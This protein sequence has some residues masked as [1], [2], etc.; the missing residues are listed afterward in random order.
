MPTDLETLRQRLDEAETA[1]H[2]L[3]L[4]ELEVTV[5]VVGFGATNYSQTNRDQLER[6]IAKLKSDIA[7]HTGLARRGP[8]FFK[9]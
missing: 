2:R 8:I 5:S 1:L 7:K 6:Y 4:G 9:F 3:I